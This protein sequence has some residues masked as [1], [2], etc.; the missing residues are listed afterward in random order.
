[1]R[2]VLVEPSHP[3]NVGSTARA[4]RVMGLTD[5][6]LV[7]PRLPEAA[8]HPDA[9]AFASGATDILA[10]CRVVPDLDAALADVSLAIAVSAA[11]RAFGPDPLEP[12]AAAALALDE[13]ARTPQATVAL[14]F[15]TERTGL[16]ITHVL[17]CQALLSIPG[18]P[19]YN[20]LN[21]AQ[22]VQ[23]VAWELRKAALARAVAGAHP[24]ATGGAPAGVPAGALAGAR[25]APRSEAPAPGSAPAMADGAQIERLFTHL[26]QALVA[27]RFLDPAHPKKLMPRLRRLFA[28]TRLE[29][30]E[31]ELLRG[32]CKQ[33]LLAAAH[34]LPRVE[35]HAAAV[36]EPHPAH[37]PPRED[38][39]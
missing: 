15:G 18:A 14:V 25:E 1:M 6:V 21:L 30:E 16:L 17:R 28:R 22:A 36:Q 33:M 37:E 29:V 27:V 38:G 9:I 23:I 32:L 10:R 35:A 39:R 20:S 8:R 2:F 7:A 13:V 4:M 5:L 24:P 11:T 3:G 19:E 31:V 34:R 12:E 26:E